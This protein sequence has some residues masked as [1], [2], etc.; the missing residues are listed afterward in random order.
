MSIRNHHALRSAFPLVC[1][2]LFGTAVAAPS[3]TVQALG[4]LGGDSRAFSINDAGKIAGYSGLYPGPQNKIGHG[5]VYYAGKLTDMGT[6]GGATSSGL[7]INAYGRVTGTA[8]NA[9]SLSRSQTYLA[10][11]MTDIGSL[12]GQYSSGTAI[13]VFGHV[14]GVSDLPNGVDQHAYLY[15]NGSMKDIGTLGGHYSW[16]NAINDTGAVVGYST[17]AGDA[18]MHAFLYS[19]GRLRD[20]GTFGAA[21]SSSEANDINN[22]GQ[23]VGSVTLASDPSVRHAFVYSAGMFTDL[24][25]GR[26]V[27][28]NDLGQV[29]LT[30]SRMYYGGV[31][32]NLNTMIDAASGWTITEVADINRKGQI[33]GYGYKAG[34]GTRALL[35][36]PICGAANSK[37]PSC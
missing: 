36:K 18:A 6:L 26:A 22:I 25:E 13:N 19:G 17:V 4:T 8:R 24:G 37:L 3:Y 15:K 20:L 30:G 12:G 7:G 1:A 5:F 27:A 14:A 9:S 11:A 33:V 35:L 23:I 2:S 31:T 28:I 21:H 34:V 29:L 32:H 10:G 16:A